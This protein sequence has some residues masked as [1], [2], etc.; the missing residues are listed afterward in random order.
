MP[1]FR[2]GVNFVKDKRKVKGNIKIV[3]ISRTT[4]YKYF[5]SVLVNTNTAIPE[6]PKITKEK[7]IGIDLGIKDFAILSNGEKIENPKFYAIHLCG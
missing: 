2:E 5:A 4:T 7:T 3:T 6:K 1:K